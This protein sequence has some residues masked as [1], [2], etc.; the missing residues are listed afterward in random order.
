MI[1]KLINKIQ[2]LIYEY[3]FRKRVLEEDLIRTRERARKPLNLPVD[4][5]ESTDCNF[6][7]HYP[8]DK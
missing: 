4:Y 7:V 1:K 5:E 3:K 8:D 2:M 6:T